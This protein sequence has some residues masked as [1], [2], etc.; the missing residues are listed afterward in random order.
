MKSP[1][2]HYEAHKNNELLKNEKDWQALLDYRND[3]VWASK[4]FK[5]S[6]AIPSGITVDQRQY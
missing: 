2:F 3:L 5:N 1:D 4:E 6:Q